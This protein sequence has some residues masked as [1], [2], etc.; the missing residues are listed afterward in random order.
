MLSFKRGVIL[1]EIKPGSKT[2]ISEMKLSSKL[3]L[4]LSQHIGKPAKPL[5][6]EGEYVKK[7]QKIAEKNSAIS[8]NIHAPASGTITQVSDNIVIETDGKDEGTAP[9][10]SQETPG[11]EE[12]IERIREAGIVGLG[13]A[14]FPTDVKLQPKNE[15]EEFIL[16]GCECEPYLTT[17]HR[18]MLEEP[19]KIIKGMKLMINACGAKKGIIAI[20]ENKKDAYKKIQKL[21]NKENISTQLV[22]TKYPQGAEKMLIY[23][24]TKKKVPTGGLPADV[25]CVVNNV[26]TAIAVCNAIHANIPLIQRVVTVTGN[27]KKPMNIDVKLGT[28]VEELL[29]KAGIKEGSKRVIMGGPMMGRALDSLQE[30]IV[31]GTSGITVLASSPP[32]YSHC[33]RCGD[34]VR[35]CP[36]NLLPTKIAAFAQKEKFREADNIYAMDCIECGCCS[37]V[38]PSAIPLV[39]YIKLAKEGIKNEVHKK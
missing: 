27:V 5:V 12:I 11:K 35:A 37:Y 39:Q 32:D 16:N 23:A 29:N 15:I 36:M 4:P 18:L 28:P 7:Y 17:D 14:C 30:P 25:G 3:T 26:A 13:G 9:G 8:A 10:N 19:E 31:K 24:L 21:A 6:S 2:K 34:C 33:I 1:P 20:E 22:K 38:C